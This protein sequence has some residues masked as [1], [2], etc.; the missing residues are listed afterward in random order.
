MILSQD[1]PKYKKSDKFLL[2]ASGFFPV[3]NEKNNIRRYCYARAEYG[4]F[5]HRLCVLR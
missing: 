1:K 4:F 5:E 2:I 3:Y